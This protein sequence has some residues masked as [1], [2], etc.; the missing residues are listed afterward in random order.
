[1][2]ADIIARGMAAKAAKLAQEALDELSKVVEGTMNEDLT[3]FTDLEGHVV[4]PDEKS[5]YLD[6]DKNLYYRWNAEEEK[7]YS[8]TGSD[9]NV[10]YVAQELTVAQKQQARINI[11]A[12]GNG[13]LKTV[14][15]MSLIGSG[16]VAI[17]RTGTR[18]LDA[19]QWD[20]NE[21]LLAI[22]GLTV[23][24]YVHII[25]S[26]SQD[27]TYIAQFGLSYSLENVGIRFTAEVKPTEDIDLQIAVISGMPL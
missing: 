27:E 19:N 21:L 12:L 15:G 13:D 10:K 14:N 1:M 22:T 8:T 17:C 18:T 25:G 20:N 16:N 4:V 3:E 5:L 11:S 23:N 6:V 9:E 26:S 7:Y 2:P 24:D